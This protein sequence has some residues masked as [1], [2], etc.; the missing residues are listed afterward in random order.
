M[1]YISRA[2]MCE[3]DMVYGRFRDPTPEELVVIDEYREKYLA[4]F[5]VYP[6]GSHW[7]D[8]V[9]SLVNMVRPGGID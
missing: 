1:N 9:H 6:A 7:V 5:G 8:G 3:T 2:Q 4:A